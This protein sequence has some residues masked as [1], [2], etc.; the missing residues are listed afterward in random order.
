MYILRMSRLTEAVEEVLYPV[1][2]YMTILL[3]ASKLVIILRVD[4]ERTDAGRTR[5]QPLSPQLV[6]IHCILH[7]GEVARLRSLPCL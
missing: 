3:T 7:R 6:W 5:K 2:R 1:T 4:V